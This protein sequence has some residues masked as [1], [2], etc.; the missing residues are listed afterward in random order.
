MTADQALAVAARRTVP[1]CASAQC[2]ECAL[3]AL[4][5]EVRRLR[6]PAEE[7]PAEATSKSR[8]SATPRA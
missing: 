8:K 3:Q 4:A 2:L 1:K 5:S 6:Q 7:K